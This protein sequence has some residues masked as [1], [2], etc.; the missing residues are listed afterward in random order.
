MSSFVNVHVFPMSYVLLIHVCLVVVVVGKYSYDYDKMI[1]IVSHI[2]HIL[3]LHTTTSSTS[4]RY[5]VVLL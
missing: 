5:I 3:L 4:Y 1:V 2:S